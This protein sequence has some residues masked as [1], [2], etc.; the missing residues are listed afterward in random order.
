MVRKHNLRYDTIS[1]KLEDQQLSDTHRQIMSSEGSA[2][3]TII[4]W[5]VA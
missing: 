2:S 4:I 3:L 1:Q 5:A